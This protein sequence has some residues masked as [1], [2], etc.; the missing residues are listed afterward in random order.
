MWN[1]KY[2]AV[3]FS[4]DDGPVQDLRM[5]EI[6]NHYHLKATFNV[7]SGFF[8]REGNPDYKDKSGN[9]ASLNE[10]KTWLAGH[11]I[12]IH[13]VN[14]P[15]LADCTEEQMFREIAEDK[16]ALEKAFGKTI[17]GMAYPF[18]SY[19]PRVMQTAA[20]CGIHYART[21]K[22]SYSFQLPINRFEFHPTCHHGDEKLEMLMEEFNAAVPSEENPV[23]LYIWGHSWEFDGSPDGWKRLDRICR[24]LADR[25]DIFYGTNAEVLNL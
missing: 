21:V 10:L 15:G 17:K 19:N 7:C 14:H 1:G 11:E 24:K 20:N 2:K 12:A 4:Y 6:L 18:G 13:S 5:A 23:L 3:T 22:S 9:Y 25:D 16:K 8:W